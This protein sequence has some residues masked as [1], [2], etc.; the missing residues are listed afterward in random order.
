MLVAMDAVI[1]RIFFLP[2]VPL[3]HVEH[4]FPHFGY[5]CSSFMK[6]IELLF[7]VQRM[8]EMV[9]QPFMLICREP[10]YL[11]YSSRILAALARFDQFGL[12]NTGYILNFLLQSLA[13]NQISIY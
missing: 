2:H 3:V 13:T 7:N 1:I 4:D 9:G 8:A 10:K 11:S 6:A 5:F 12:F